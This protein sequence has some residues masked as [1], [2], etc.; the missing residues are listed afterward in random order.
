[1][2]EIRNY[3]WK[4]QFTGGP[5]NTMFDNVGARHGVPLNQ[6]PTHDLD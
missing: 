4:I 1:M 6:S 3:I 5:M 2:N